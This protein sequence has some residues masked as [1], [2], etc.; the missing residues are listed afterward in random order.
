MSDPELL[1]TM[2]PKFDASC[3]PAL[4][5]KTRRTFYENLPAARHP[6]GACVFWAT[7]TSRGP[8][9]TL[10][11]WHA[12]RNRH[13]P[14][15][16]QHPLPTLQQHG[17]GHRLVGSQLNCLGCTNPFTEHS[18]R[19]DEYCTVRSGHWSNSATG[20][21]TWTTRTRG[22]LPVLCKLP[23]RS[24]TVPPRHFVVKKLLDRCGR[25]C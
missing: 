4:R 20:T 11:Q 16:R 13:L 23:T 1:C 18:H 9:N 5:T 6:E 2:A 8:A 14:C 12:T 17:N 24:L 21:T 19:I 10:D 3:S 7:D 25:I 22:E 15:P